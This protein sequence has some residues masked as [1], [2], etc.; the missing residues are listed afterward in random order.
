MNL[1]LALTVS[2]AQGAALAA[3]G[4]PDLDPDSGLAQGMDES[5]YCAYV[6]GVAGSESSLLLA[7]D[8]VAEAGV[9]RTGALGD[10]QE[11]STGVLSPRLRV[12]A[13]LQYGIARLR[14]GMA[15]RDRA[16]AECARYT[17]VSALLRFVDANEEAVSKPA[18]A[19]KLA[20]LAAALPRALAMVSEARDAMERSRTTV[21]E[22]NALEVRAEAIREA[23][24]ETRR[25]A[26]SIRG[27]RRA[28]GPTLAEL[29]Q[30][31]SSA[32]Q[33]VER[34]EAALRH[35]RAWDLSFVGGYEQISGLEERVPL[36]GRA[37][38][39]MR[40]GGLF[41]A[42]SDASAFAARPVWTRNQAAG[43]DDRVD[44]TL[45]RL[46]AALGAANA[47]LGT[48]ASLRA[49]LDERL[50]KLLDLKTDRVR[51]FRDEI[52]FQLVQADADH[53][54]LRVQIEELTALLAGAP[55]TS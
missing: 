35:V 23:I 6:Q 11:S 24:E 8:I 3:P 51:R 44:Q 37:T 54:F 32:E 10:A 55:P 30:R 47:R 28:G 19:A 5:A 53:A 14:E 15:L 48:V 17:T 18:L 2:L 31:H 25:H 42:A 22:V 7:P 4:V 50:N 29:L 52:W 26:A 38:L 34:S 43:V 12:T 21:E 9:Y 49:D 41:Q 20:V 13:G 45:R 16:R 40:I 36:F 27:T 33:Q 39:T 1:I 46:R